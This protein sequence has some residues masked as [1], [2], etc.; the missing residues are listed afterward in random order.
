MF[1]DKIYSGID[2]INGNPVYSGSVIVADGCGNDG[3]THIVEIYKGSFGSDVYGD[4]DPLSRYKKI[5]V[6]GHIN[7]SIFECENCGAT[8]KY[9]T[10]HHSADCV[11]NDLQ[12]ERIK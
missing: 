12:D 10:L 6:I 7:S 11:D 4:F 5:K 8:G 1:I 9:G 2:D 3:S